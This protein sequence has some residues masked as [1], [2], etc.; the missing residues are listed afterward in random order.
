[1]TSMIDVARK[2]GVSTAT[3]SRVLANKPHVRPEVRDRV[4]DAVEALGYRPN[5]VASNLRKQTSKVIGLLVSDIRNPFFTAVARAIED[6]ALTNGYSVFLCN[7]DEDHDKELL[8]L[9]NLISENAAGIILS[10]TCED[11]EAYKAVLGDSIPTVLIDRRVDAFAVDVVES[12]NFRSAY[13]LTQH[14]LAQG[15]QSP[16]A[17]IGLKN[18]STGRDRMGGIRSALKDGGKQIDQAHFAYVHPREI[19]GYAEMNRMLGLDHRPDAI[20]TGN[21]RLTIGVL[22]AMNE[23]GLAVCDDVGLAGFD[24]TNWTPFLE[25]GITVISQPTYEMGQ[26]AAELLL[27]L[28]NKEDRAPR[29]VTL[30]GE[31]VIRKSTSRIS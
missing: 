9:E 26:T 1:M 4:L 23:H 31:L 8:Y 11:P 21:S 6:I 16:G 29:E 30:K 27:S 28:I 7:T 25:G 10:P 18:S 2:A 13:K 17:I 3:V 24:E 12:D 5:R 19:E 20:I 22:K 15:Y 14:L